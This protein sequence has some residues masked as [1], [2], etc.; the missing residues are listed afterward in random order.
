[1]G[2]LLDI[3]FVLTHPF[4]IL[5]LT[6]AI[7]IA[8]SVVVFLVGLMTG[9]SVR[10]AALA[11]L[12]LSQVGEFSFVLASYGILNG[13]GTVYLHEMFI[14][15]AILTM[16][17]TPYVV[18]ASPR[19]ANLMLNLPFA[20]SLKTGL[21]AGLI[22]TEKKDHVIIIGFGFSGRNL[23]R[24]SKEAGVSYVV[25]DMNPETVREQRQR[26]EPITFGDATRER[27]LKHANIK[28]AS[29]LAILINDP[30]AALRIVEQ[31][32]NINPS[33]YIIVRTRYLQEM[34]ALYQL[35]ADEVIPDELGS[36]VEIFSRVLLRYKVPPEKLEQL[37]EALRKEGYEMIR[38]RYG[39]TTIFSDLKEYLEDV[40]VKT[41][42]LRDNS[43]FAGRTLKDCDLRRNWG[44]T[45]IVIKRENIPIYHI[46]AST[47][48]EAGDQ[49]VVIGTKENLAHTDQLFNP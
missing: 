28:D 30:I 13:I 19:I 18:H 44:L 3:N 49:V 22:G 1:M 48:L 27:V 25:I 5:G 40:G 37:V 34:R 46:D 43:P 12:S 31:A 2:M 42:H 4:G 14:A 9:A 10:T 26:G 23:A 11:G 15:V 20:S 41:I 21:E 38:P 39:E 29:V 24:S 8:K 17:I 35:G 36:T 7:F 45:V 16:G 32:K 6:A 33:V 47:T